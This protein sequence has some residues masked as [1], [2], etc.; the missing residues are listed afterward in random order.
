MKM[1][2]VNTIDNSPDPM[3]R[4][5]LRLFFTQLALERDVWGI[6]DRWEEFLCWCG[7]L[8]HLIV[9]V[10]VPSLLEAERKKGCLRKRAGSL[11][12][13]DSLSKLPSLEGT[14]PT[15]D[16]GEERG[17]S[18]SREQVVRP[19]SR[20]VE[21]LYEHKAALSEVTRLQASLQEGNVWSLVI[22][23]YLR[24]DIHCRREEFE[25]SHYS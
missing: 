22:A 23:E 20:E 10:S 11:A 19:E 18:L 16:L 6:L 7:T 24:S 13:E 3:M 12:E 1:G 21:F 4:W 9:A 17:A 2:D 8:A 14:P 25:H 15:T 5:K